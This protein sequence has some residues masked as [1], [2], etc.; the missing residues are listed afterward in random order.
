MKKVWFWIVVALVIIG[1]LAFANHVPFWVSLTTATAFIAGGVVS[2][3][4]HNIYDKYFQDK[5]ANP[6]KEGDTSLQ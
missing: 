5:V 4:I 3:I 1:I 2:W 6:D